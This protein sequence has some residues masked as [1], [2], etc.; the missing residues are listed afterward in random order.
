ML[1]HLLNPIE[2]QDLIIYS[3]HIPALDPVIPALCSLCPAWSCG[4]A[5]LRTHCA[6]LGC[7]IPQI[8]SIVREMKSL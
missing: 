5:A 2:L 7:I 3:D 1:T 6:G 4:P 8:V